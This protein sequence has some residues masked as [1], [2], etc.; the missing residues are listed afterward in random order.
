M[1]GASR[2]WCYV[3][4]GFKAVVPGAAYCRDLRF[5]QR[6]L[7]CRECA[8]DGLRSDGGASPEINLNLGAW[9]EAETAPAE[10]AA[11]E[12]EEVMKPETLGEALGRLRRENGLS[13]EKAALAVGI[14]Q[15]TLCRWEQGRAVPTLD[16]VRALDAVYVSDLAERFRDQLPVEAA[17]RKRGRPAPA[18]AAGPEPVEA[19]PAEQADAPELGNSSVQV[20][21]EAFENQTQNQEADETAPDPEELVQPARPPR[22]MS[23]A[24][25]VSE[26]VVIR[27]LVEIVAVLVRSVERLTRSSLCGRS[28]VLSPG[29]A[30]GPGCDRID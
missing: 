2:C 30:I 18:P 17:R 11:A 24:P 6:R 5:G 26:G 21:D 14:G 12:S 9:P 23:A 3:R 27:Q 8:G 22:D 20:E 7:Y 13:Q 16:R 28:Q 25:V 4:A 10:V 1:A 29:K 19:P 15:G